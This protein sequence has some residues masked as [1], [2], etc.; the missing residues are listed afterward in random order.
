MVIAS[1]GPD[2]AA[3]GQF[4]TALEGVR[5]ALDSAAKAGLG[6]QDPAL[7]DLR[8]A[9]VALEQGLESARKAEPP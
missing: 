5:S 4:R 2:A 6:E 9:E 7:D 1:E 8:Q 3:E